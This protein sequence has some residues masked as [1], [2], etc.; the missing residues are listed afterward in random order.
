MRKNLRTPERAN[1]VTMDDNPTRDD[2]P[3][4]VL[5]LADDMGFSDIG[6]FGSEIATPNLDRL[7]SSGLRFSQMY[8][9][10]RCCPSRASLMT[11]ISPHRAGI[12]HMVKDLHVPGYRGF[13]NSNCV[14]VAE[15]LRDAGYQTLMSGKW[16][17]GGEYDMQNPDAWSAGDAGHPVPTQRGFDQHFG[18]LIGAGSFFHPLTLFENDHHIT[19]DSPDFYYTDAIADKAVE[20]VDN[21]SGKDKP[22][23]LYTAFTAPHWPLHAF[24]EDIAKYEGKYRGGWDKLRTNRHEELRDSGVLESR[25]DIT[26]RDATAPAWKD[27]E[28]I[29]WEDLRMATYVAQ[30]DRMDQGIGRILDALEKNRVRD[31][32]VVIF[33]S[34]NGGCAEFLAEDSNK[35]EP[36]HFDTPPIDGSTMRF[37]NVPGLR[38]GPGNTFMSYDLPWSNA[39]NAPFRLYKHWVHEGG[40]STPF[41]IS[42]PNKIKEPGISHSPAQLM[43]ITATCIDLAGATYP[44][45]FDGNE[46]AP[47]EGESFARLLSGKKWQREQ[48]IIWEHEGNRAVRSGEWKLVSKFPGQW[49]LYNMTE[50]R[51]ELHNLVD[52]D[53][54]RV[55]SLARVYGDWAETSH[56]LPWP[57]GGDPRIPASTTP[58]AHKIE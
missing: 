33:L 20:M 28:N 53:A 14:T 31:N 43:D 55:A 24:E 2:R 45:E 46:I 7:A 36:A 32:T 23:F 57:I 11:G 13:L 4:I 19:P 16:H 48:P 51:T 54:A 38:P 58:N 34:D 50:D 5:I 1:A 21:A 52:G 22:F 17:V 37:G 18:T 35:P 8:N 44:S 49:E 56:V 30:I 12:G 39:S 3:N 9:Y 40:I 6:C 25:W 29:D 27:A 15:V 47:L 42:W 41:I 26:P 10:A